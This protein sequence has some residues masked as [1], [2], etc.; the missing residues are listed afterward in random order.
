ME[1]YKEGDENVASLEEKESALVLRENR[2][3]ERDLVRILIE[4]KK[5]WQIAGPTLVTRLALFAMNIITQSFAGHLG[6]LELAS[7]SISN[8]VIA[9]FNFG[10]LVSSPSLI[11]LWLGVYGDFRPSYITPN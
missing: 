4:S 2:D 9:G 11:F 8:G 6:D 10:V 3:Q 1:S 5:L 7:I